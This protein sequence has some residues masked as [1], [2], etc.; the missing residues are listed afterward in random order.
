M[1]KRAKPPKPMILA[2]A[3]RSMM[4]RESM[5]SVMVRMGMARVEVRPI[6]PFS[7]PAS[8][9]ERSHRAMNCGSRVAVACMPSRFRPR[10]LHM[11]QIRAVG[12]IKPIS[13]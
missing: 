13:S 8:V 9:P 5:R 6:M 12:F 4:R 7:Q 11:I 2:Q 1:A 3:P 10:K